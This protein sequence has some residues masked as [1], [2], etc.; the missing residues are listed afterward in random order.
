MA[1][2]AP[3]PHYRGMIGAKQAVARSGSRMNWL[4]LQLILCSVSL[5]ACAQIALKAGMASPKVQHILAGAGAFSL[6]DPPFALIG[7]FFAPMVLLGL[8]LYFASA[9]LWLLVLARID[10]SSAYPFAALGIVLTSVLGRV[11]LGEAMSVP[12]I[13]GTLLIVGG[14][15]VLAGG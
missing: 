10:V 7:L 8:S 6:S 12:K 1:A 13:A 11:L 2:I 3:R 15:A 14:V 4:T 5:T 9:A